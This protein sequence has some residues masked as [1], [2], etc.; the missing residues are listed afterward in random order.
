MITGASGFVGSA[1]VQALVDHEIFALGRREPNSDIAKFMYAD[2]ASPNF[3]PGLFAGIDVVI[4]CAAQVHVMSDADD[5]VIGDFDRVNHVATRKLAERA[6][7][8]GVKRFIFLSTIKVN[9]EFTAQDQCFYFDDR[10]NPQ[11]AYSKSKALAE[12]ALQDI[13]TRTGMEYVIIRPPLIYGLGV[14]GNFASLTRLVRANIPLPLAS[15]RNSRSILSISN[16][17]SL[18]RQCVSDPRAANEIFLVSDEEK[19]STPSLVAVMNKAFGCSSKVFSVPVWF[20][21]FVARVFGKQ[22]YAERLCQS[23]VVDTAHTREILDWQPR[24]NVL[25]EL[26]KFT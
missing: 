23:L 15:I 5:R 4:H 6:A 10:P 11:C 17:C 13:S 16:L 20:L 24:N 18:I 12:Q 14:R 9:G 26:K 3:R 8:E 2:L 22:R 7:E 25:D 21:Y 1:L 19:L